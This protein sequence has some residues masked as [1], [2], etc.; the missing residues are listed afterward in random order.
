MRSCGIGGL[1]RSILHLLSREELDMPPENPDYEPFA[2]L[3]RHSM[4]DKEPPEHTRLRNL[5]HRAF[6]PQRIRDLQHSIQTIAN[7]LL[8][9]IAQRDEVDILANYAA[10]LSVTVIATLLGVPEPDHHKL[11]PWSNA[12]VKMYEL[13]HTPQQAT[14]AVHASQ[15]FADYLIALAKQRKANPQNDLITALALVEDEGDKLTENELV[16]TCVLLLNAG[17]EATVNVV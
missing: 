14:D 8:D 3:G 1:G 9:D 16:S 2:K 7:N 4:F 12:I 5:V 6:T 15:E 11:R 10:P 17:H 13:G